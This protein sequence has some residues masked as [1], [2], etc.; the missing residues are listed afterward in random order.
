MP[1]FST[2]MS[3]I[4]SKV[5]VAELKLAHIEMRGDGLSTE[6]CPLQRFTY[7]RDGHSLTGKG[8]IDIQD[9]Y[10][11]NRRGPLNRFQRAHRGPIGVRRVSVDKLLK[12]PDAGPKF[13]I[14]HHIL[15]NNYS[16]SN[17]FSLAC[18]RQLLYSIS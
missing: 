16:R 5:R 3:S 9:L 14:D 6:S 18:I 4:A 13:V 15:L 17:V 11:A 1:T 10:V 8:I 2:P 12:H 7:L